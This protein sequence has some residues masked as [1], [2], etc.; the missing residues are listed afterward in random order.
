M[1][2][3]I[4]VLVV[5]DSVFMRQIIT[6]ILDSDPGIKV[7]AAAKNGEEAL[8]ALK[9]DQFD[10]I[11]LDINMPKMD[12]ITALKHIMATNP[13]P[14][15]MISALTQEGAKE[16]LQALSIGAL[17]YVAKPSGA[18]SFDIDEQRDEIV[19]KVKAAAGSK[20]RRVKPIKAAREDVKEAKPVK[21]VLPTG[22][23][24]GAS[25]LVVAIGASTGGPTTLFEIIPLLPKSL[26]A[27]VI[28][29]QHMPPLFTKTFAN[30]LNDVSR[31]TVK[32]AEDNEFLKKSTVYVANGNG[33]LLVEREPGTDK[34]IIKIDTQTKRT[35]SPNVNI[36][37]DSLV[38]TCKQNIIGVL[39]TGMGIDG[40]NG[41]LNIKNAG[42]ITI[43]EDESTSI[44]FGMPK[45]AIRLG[46]AEYILP[47]GEIANKIISLVNTRA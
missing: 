6:T 30:R 9:D 43:A 32:E 38:E 36:T 44:I 5:D 47:S 15:I 23:V 4:R 42:G 7:T 26:N 28:L 24:S 10:V 34:K 11:T 12:G 19:S 45:E 29:V 46:G 25:D 35:Y 41:M 22:A 1:E 31:I 17:D 14:V 40:A 2:K 27:S 33:H 13:V 20:L 37:F 21:E 8:Q 39:I 3:Q 18:I 16:T